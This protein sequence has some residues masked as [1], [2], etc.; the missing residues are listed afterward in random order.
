MIKLTEYN[1]KR[2]MKKLREHFYVAGK[3]QDDVFTNCTTQELLNALDTIY[4]KDMDTSQLKDFFHKNFYFKYSNIRNNEDKRNLSDAMSGILDNLQIKHSFNLSQKDMENIF[5]FLATANAFISGDKISLNFKELAYI[6]LI[7]FSIERFKGPLL[8]NIL[9]NEDVSNM[10]IKRITIHDKDTIFY[11]L[12]TLSKEHGNLEDIPLSV[13]NSISKHLMAYHKLK[14]DELCLIAL[15]TS[16]EVAKDALIQSGYNE[17]V[18]ASFLSNE[19]ISEEVRDDYAEIYEYDPCLLN[20]ETITKKIFNQIFMQTYESLFE[21]GINGETRT[22]CNEILQKLAK[23]K[24]MP[25]S[26]QIDIAHRLCSDE[27]DTGMSKPLITNMTSPKALEI[28]AENYHEADSI[29]IF[30]N[31]NC[32]KQLVIDKLKKEVDRAVK[33]IKKSHVIV[34][35]RTKHIREI[36]MNSYLDSDIL[37]KIYFMESELPEFQFRDY[38]KSNGA[39][40]EALKNFSQEYIVVN[41]TIMKNRPHI[42]FFANCIYQTREQGLSVEDMCK[43]IDIVE[44]IHKRDKTTYLKIPAMVKN[45]REKYK[46]YLHIIDNALNNEYTDMDTKIKFS[47][48]KKNLDI[49]QKEIDSVFYYQDF[50][51]I[52]EEFY[53]QGIFIGDQIQVLLKNNEKLDNIIEQY[54]KND[55]LR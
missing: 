46:P 6:H 24:R 25:E 53:N 39:T 3:S 52:N 38:L 55:V 12:F 4:N 16:E 8:A 13:R 22:K 54:E 43:I 50:S 27:L 18:V 31:A 41:D 9:K 10:F 20:F 1:F 19:S 44:S 7:G 17:E 29:H 37:S 36:A 5:G 34:L 51:N 23:T 28:L 42:A 11:S 33:D 35:D 26:V 47:F 32:P 14:E 45:D 21:F 30:T 49:S 40:M 48:V 15:N 2:Y